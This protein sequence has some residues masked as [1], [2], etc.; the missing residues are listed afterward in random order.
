MLPLP[1]DSFEYVD[2]L[3][4]HLAYAHLPL[5]RMLLRALGLSVSFLLEDALELV[6]EVVKQKV[7][8]QASQD[9]LDRPEEVL[10]DVVQ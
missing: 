5:L 4:V 3:V 9:D 6:C 1:D 8:W 7:V 2:D 10:L